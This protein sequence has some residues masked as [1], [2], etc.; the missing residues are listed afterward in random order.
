MFRNSPFSGH[1]IL[2]LLVILATGCQPIVASGFPQETAVPQVAKRRAE[3]DAN[4]TAATPLASP[5]PWYSERPRYAPGERVDY[6][7]QAGDTLP[8]WLPVQHLRRRNTGSQFLYSSI[9]N[10]HAAW[11]AHENPDLLSAAVGIS[12]PDYS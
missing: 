6:I 8:F 11:H 2:A 4:L 10:H 1:Q 9:C 3:S 5:T 7:A 12:F